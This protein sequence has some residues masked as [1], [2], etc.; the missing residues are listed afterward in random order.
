MK[1]R[2]NGSLEYRMVLENG[3][4]CTINI[5]DLRALQ[6]KD[7]D[8]AYAEGNGWHWNYNYPG[9]VEMLLASGPKTMVLTTYEGKEIVFWKE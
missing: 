4:P 6:F 5:M 3:E 2:K 9:R 8:I 7:G 1:I